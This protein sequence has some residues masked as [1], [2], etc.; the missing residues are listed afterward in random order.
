MTDLELQQQ[1]KAKWRVDGRAVRTLE[2]ARVFVEEVGMCLAYP[3]RPALPLPTW[4]GAYTG[5]DERLPDAKHAFNDPRAREAEELMVRLLREK[6]AFESNLMGESTLLVSASLFPYFYALVAAQEKKGTSK[7][8]KLSQ[9]A[10]DVL[11][12]VQQ[13]GAVGKQQLRALLKGEPSPAALDRALAELW[14][15]LKITRVG[16]NERE[17]A[18]WDTFARWA[19][20]AVKEG[21]GLSTGEALSAVLSKYLDMAIAAEPEE[22]ENVLS[23][24]APRSRIKEAVNALLA[25]RE[26]S[27]A[28][29]G[30]RTL[31]QIT[32]ARSEQPPRAERPAR[33]RRA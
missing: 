28:H 14:S 22:L 31:V 9:L 7:G 24:L 29:A 6:A 8:E 18:L 12:V 10:L 20:A 3:V 17:G 15:R 1:R 16:Y 32:P 21:A 19:P 5:S 27:F 4:I 30:P 23:P 33:R 26:L 2:D 13:K 25:A 11:K